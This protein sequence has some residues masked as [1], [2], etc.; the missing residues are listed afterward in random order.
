M[1]ASKAERM[2]RMRRLGQRAASRLVVKRAL[3]PMIWLCAV[4]TPSFLLAANALKDNIILSTLFGLMAAVPVLVTC[5]VVV[6]LGV[7]KNGATS[8]EGLPTRPGNAGT[9]LP[10]RGRSHERFTFHGGPHK[11]QSPPD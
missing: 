11:P 6:F 3:N 5:V 2:A 8:L 7:S 1:F 9:G 10:A 4:T